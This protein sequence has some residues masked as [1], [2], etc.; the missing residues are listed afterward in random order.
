MM[1]PM[2]QSHARSFAF[3]FRAWSLLA[4]AALLLQSPA[5][6]QP[7][8]PPPVPPAAGND[9]GAAAELPESHDAVATSRMWVVSTHASPQSFDDQCPQFCPGVLKYSPCCGYTRAN[10]SELLDSLQPGLPVCIFVHGS[11]VSWEDVCFEAKGTFDWLRRDCPDSPLQFISLTWP[12]DRPI[13]PLVAIDVLQ[14]GRRAERNGFYLADLINC[15]PRESTVSLIGHSHGVRVISSALH[16]MAGGSIQG[17]R[18][19][20]ANC[21]GRRI[22]VV[23]AAAAMDHD[24]LN[25]GQRY[26]R[27]LCCTQCLL[28]LEN[29]LDPA[30]K[31]YPLRRPF[32]S[33]ALGASGFTR[34]DES[35]LGRNRYRIRTVDISEQFGM[36][37]NWPEYIRRPWLARCIRNYVHFTDTATIAVAQ[38]QPQPDP[39]AGDAAAKHTRG[40]DVPAALSQDAAL[41]SVRRAIGMVP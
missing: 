19:P 22:R 31:V 14:L 29:C 40:T 26:D 10:F 28:N 7:V 5:W 1:V 34:K 30:L 6:S 3:R 25:P 23:F 18:K 15:V 17:L 9:D 11:F 38:R 8:T 27:A 37:H 39:A 21:S 35:R 24:W 36:V 32:S 4:V 16:L 33:R 12:S 13:T 41:G 2:R 20:C